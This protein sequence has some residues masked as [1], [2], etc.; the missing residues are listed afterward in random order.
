MS[1][2][3]TFDLVNLVMSETGVPKKFRLNNFLKKNLIVLKSQG[4]FVLDAA[5]E[6][7]TAKKKMDSPK[8]ACVASVSVGFRSKERGTRV[9]DYAKNGASKREGRGGEESFLLSTPSP[10][11]FIFWLSFHFSGGQTRPFF[12]PKP[13]ENACYARYTQM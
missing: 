12:A 11:S 1:D 9:K 7:V 8:L 6:N 2:D 4:T 13:N 3:V 5:I 10:P